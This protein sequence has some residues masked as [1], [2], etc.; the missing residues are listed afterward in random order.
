MISPRT[1]ILLLD[2]ARFPFQESK[3][4]LG[5]HCQSPSIYY[6]RPCAMCYELQQENGPSTYIAI[7]VK[8]KRKIELSNHKV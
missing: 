5:I 3:I 6:H 1:I 4:Y 8:Y 2:L 7:L